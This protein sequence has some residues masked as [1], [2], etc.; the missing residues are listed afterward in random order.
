MAHGAGG[1]ILEGLERRDMQLAF[2]NLKEENDILQRENKALRDTLLQRQ[3]ETT[4]RRIIRFHNFIPC[5]DQIMT[6]DN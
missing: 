3:V 2:Q 6:Y 5:F 1:A 4:F